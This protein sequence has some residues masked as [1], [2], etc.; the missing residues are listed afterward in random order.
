MNNTKTMMQQQMEVRKNVCVCRNFGL[1]FSGTL[2]TNKLGFELK[3]NCSRDVTILLVIPTH[4]M[5]VTCKADIF[6]YQLTEWA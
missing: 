3:K 1:F 5:G 2:W 4:S 6:L